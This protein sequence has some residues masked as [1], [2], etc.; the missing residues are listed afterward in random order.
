MSALDLSATA[1]RT[2]L[3]GL[4]DDTSDDD[5]VVTAYARAIWSVLTEPGDGVAGALVMALGPVRAL[6][7]ALANTGGGDE[8]DAAGLAPRDLSG[9]RARWQ[10]RAGGA[11]VP[12][13]LARRAGVD[14][15][16]P[17]HAAWPTRADDLGPYAPLCLWVRGDV[18]A[19]ASDSA[20]WHVAE[21]N[22]AL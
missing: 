11:A 10:P 3:A 19:L 6:E 8:A 22:L 9:G 18:G 15:L 14:L 17:E 5:D 2:A 21:L 4:V 7:I 20:D 16:T 1:A 13:D 12:L